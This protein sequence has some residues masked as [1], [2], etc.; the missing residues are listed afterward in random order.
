MKLLTAVEWMKRSQE[1]HAIQQKIT[2]I[3]RRQVMEFTQRLQ[4]MQ[5]EAYTIFGEIEGQGSHLDQVVAT[6][7][8]CL[9]GSTKE[10]VI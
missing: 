8:Q 10:Q 1:E 6:V 5:G 2:A 3:Q 4:S 7:E 9:E